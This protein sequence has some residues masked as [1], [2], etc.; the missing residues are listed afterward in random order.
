MSTTWLNNNLK[1]EIKSIFEPLYH[2]ELTDKEIDEI[3]DNLT[4]LI[5]TIKKF[6]WKQKYEYNI[7]RS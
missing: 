1:M 5:E 7:P 4:S 3:A 6:R 2:R